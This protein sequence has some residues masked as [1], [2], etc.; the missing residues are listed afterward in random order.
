MSEP[1]GQC[2]RGEESREVGVRRLKAPRRRVREEM[3]SEGSVCSGVKLFTVSR[4]RH[5]S[6]LRV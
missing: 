2:A 6:R 3:G 5:I 4:D 1:S